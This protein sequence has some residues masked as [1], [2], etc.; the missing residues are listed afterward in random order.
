MRQITGQQAPS[1]ALRIASE[2]RSS[3]FIVGAPRTG[4][5]S[6]AKALEVWR[7]YERAY[8]S[9]LR[10]E[11]RCLAEGSVTYLI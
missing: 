2:R 7:R 9:G 8:F 11:H 4:T 5:T 6:L 1:Q 3:L 10:A